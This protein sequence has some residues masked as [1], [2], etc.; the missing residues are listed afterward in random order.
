MIKI[1]NL[2]K[3]Y[4]RNTKRANTV[5]RDVSLT[6]PDKGFVCI[7]GESGCGKTSLL[8]AIGGLDNFDSG[9]ITTENA[10]IKSSRSSAMEKERNS[11]FGYIFQNYYLLGSHSVA[12]NIFLGLHTLPI[13][14]KEKLDRI[15]Y[16][17]ER[18]DM[19]RYKRRR[20]DQLSGG[21]QQ[22]VAIARAI[23]RSPRVIF[24]DE[25]TGN[26]DEANTLS[27]C[28]LLKEIS[29]ESLVV[30]VTH[31]E[32]IARFFADRI[33]TLKDGTVASDISDWEKE[34]MDAGAKDTLYA[35]EYREEK[36]E[37]ESVSL[38]LLTS[39]KAEGVELTVIA[40][41]DRIIIKMNDPRVVICSDVNTA[42][43]LE[44]GNRPVLDKK[45]LDGTSFE[46]YRHVDPQKKKRK[47]GLGLPMLLREAGALVTENKLRKVGTGLFI[48]LL[49][50][51]LSISIADAVA[52]AHIDP[53]DFI[54][55]DSH[56]LAFNIGRGAKLIDKYEP[57]TPHV[58][59]YR[60]YIDASELDF[61][62]IPTSGTR[63]EYYDNTVAQY[64]E[65]K[66][67]FY[68][69]SRVNI[70]R[71]DPDTIIYGRM[72]ERSDEIV[73]DRWVL[74]KM[75]GEEGVL[76]NII[77]DAEYLLGKKLSLTKKT[78]S[79]TIVGICDSGEPSIYMSK[80]MLLAYAS[81][82][83][84]VMTLSEFKRI[85]GR[86]DGIAELKNDECIVLV[87]N[88]GIVYLTRTD[89]GPLVRCD[90]NIKSVGA[91]E[92]T[93]DSIG[94]KIIIAD[95]ALD[96]LY[97]AVVNENDNFVLWC[98]DKEKMMEYLDSPMP[99]ELKG[100]L[101]VKVID[102]YSN[103]YASYEEKTAAKLDGR[104]I[105]IISTLLASA[106]MLYLMQRAN[107]RDHGDLVAVYRLL[108]I[109]KRELVLVFAVESL[110]QT[111]KFALPTVIVIWLGLLAA[112]YIEILPSFE[113]LFPIEAA[114]VTF[115]AI[116]L[117][118]LIVAAL[119]ILRLMSYPPA[120]LAAKYD[121]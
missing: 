65:L 31:E 95:T 12:Y 71:L 1:D 37:G 51:M 4:D 82:G 84:E 90:Y 69:G 113:L 77:P 116:A 55:T 15:K 81:Y 103:A 105:I 49:T 87:D 6:L 24:A 94:A 72:P 111:L 38:R 121:F 23:A 107:I 102:S 9:K 67:E 16:A 73:I 57:V 93:D 8:N 18:V 39:D 96:P 112:P 30:M 35:E 117:F 104:T 27:I 17:L 88:A 42:P 47:S 36:V 85:T 22:R 115:G 62:Y 19:L 29:K 34:E 75:L 32:R 59:V 86:F 26:L 98:S 118:R 61:D 3:T 76:Q 40:E 80:E 91:L 58:N 70:S 89:V 7:L 110:I 66:M 114:A 44:E 54:T 101:D 53:E 56:T 108:G 100:M 97:R 28:S 83:V 50:V 119:P 43:Y 2:K 41:K 46:G 5:L 78:V 79:P 120:R 25:P 92:N 21:Q 13:S 20:V 99:E 48:V 64:G 11:S 109:P 74:D 52:V 106:V 60:E 45:S 68:M 63:L 33:I 10:E 14:R